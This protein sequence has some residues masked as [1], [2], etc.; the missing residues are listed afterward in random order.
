MQDI[1]VQKMEHWSKVKE[2]Y[3]YQQKLMD[4]SNSILKRRLC[5]LENILKEKE[6]EF[7]KKEKEVGQL[8]MFIG[9]RKDLEE[10]FRKGFEFLGN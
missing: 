7:L 8:K 2:E 9:E 6:R 3:E 4:Q 1:F 5:E 10:E